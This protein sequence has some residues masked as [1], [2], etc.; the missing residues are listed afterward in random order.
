MRALRQLERQLVDFIAGHEHGLCVLDGEPAQLPWV[1]A[2]LQRLDATSSDVFLPFPHAFASSD[3]YAGTIAEGLL[4]T[5][6]EVAGDAQLEL[7]R[8]CIDPRRT[9]VERVRAAL[10]FGRAQMLAPGAGSPRLVVVLVPLT[11]EDEDA[12][13]AFVRGLVTAPAGWPPWFHRMRIFLHA[14]RC[15]FAELPRFVGS[16]AVDLSPA[17]LQASVVE[18]AQDPDAPPQRRAEALLQAAALDAVSGRHEAAVVGYR[19]VHA[20]ADHAKSPVLAALALHG[21]GDVAYARRDMLEALA[22]YERALVPAS[23]TGA[24]LVMLIVTQSLARLYFELDRRADA[25]TFYDGA[26]RLAMV[27][28]DA[29]SHAQALQWRGRLQELRGAVDDAA[30]SYLA[31]ARVAR[32]HEHSALLDELRPRLHASVLRVSEP[33]R[34]ELAAFLGGGQ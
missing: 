31:A 7:P 29:T 14:R 27:V 16:M 23:S 4:A 15:S 20:W 26:Q 28:P 8:A 19:Q 24:A 30:T 17:A 6:R 1:Y 3:A 11:V 9:A 13:A 22:W 33:L 21:I 34:R 5:A 18:E 12:A 32:E 10:E 25:E 2:A